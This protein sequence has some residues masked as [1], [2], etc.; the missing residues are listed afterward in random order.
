M[1]GWFAAVIGEKS[2]SGMI[3]NAAREVAGLTGYA[4]L[5]LRGLIIKAEWIP[6]AEPKGGSVHNER[7]PGDFRALV[8]DDHK[9]SR[10]FTVAALRQCRATVKRARNARRALQLAVE[11]RPHLIF[12]DIHLR[13]LNGLEL[14]RQIRRLWPAGQPPPRFIVLSGDRTGPS[15]SEMERLEIDCVLIKPVDSALIRRAANLHRQNEIM[16][17]VAAKSD[18]HELFRQEL[19]KRLATLDRCMAELDLSGVRN[20]LHQLI[21]SSAICGEPGLEASMRKLDTHCLE[22]D[23]PAQLARAY[24]R[25]L[26]SSRDYLGGLRHSVS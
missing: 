12:M 13:G 20:I 9:I 2:R 16:E 4:K 11:W 8:V 15:P 7:L 25:L 17:E 3:S 23:S 1:A 6:V 22:H 5:K 21:A 14:I 24:F 26:T 19:D 18:L 10:C